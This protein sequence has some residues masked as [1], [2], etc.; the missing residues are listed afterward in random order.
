MVWGAIKYDGT[1]AL[2]KCDK[3][4]TSEEYQRILDVGLLP[5]YRPNELLQQDGAPC[6]RSKKNF[7]FLKKSKINVV[8]DWPAQSPDLNI[9][10]PLWKIMKENVAKRKPKNLD[11]VWEYCQD[12]WE[13]IPTEKIQ[14][15]Y[16]SL[17]KRIRA[18]LD[19]KASHKK[20]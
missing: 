4:V 18:V 3:S 16:E 20:Y 13:K 19:T 17:P 11:E 12:E 10:E 15:L 2:M 14:V 1:R 9:I 5:M 8:L 6:H 7:E